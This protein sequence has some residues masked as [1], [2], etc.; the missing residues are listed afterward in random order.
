MLHTVTPASLAIL[1]T[2]KG[3]SLERFLPLRLFDVPQYSRPGDRNGVDRYR[4]SSI[5]L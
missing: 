2:T 4:D 1:T 5:D 3:A